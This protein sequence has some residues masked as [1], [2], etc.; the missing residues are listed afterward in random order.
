MGVRGNAQMMRASTGEE[1]STGAAATPGP[2]ETFDETAQRLFSAFMQ[3]P[4]D[5]RAMNEIMYYMM[6]N[7]PNR[8]GP[9]PAAKRVVESLE[10]ETIDEE[11]AKRLETCAICTEDFAAGDRI[12][13]LSNDR[14]LCG[15]GFHVDCILPWLRQ[16]N[17]C[18]VCRYE[19]PTDDEQYN[20]QRAQLRSRLVE[21]VQRHVDP[22]SQPNSGRQSFSESG[23][24]GSPAPVETVADND[25]TASPADAASTANPGPS[26][27]AE[28]AT[29]G[30]SNN[31]RTS[32][33]RRQ[34]SGG[35]LIIETNN[36]RVQ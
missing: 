5:P 15:H 27:P 24:T 17:S 22:N 9:P 16:H 2:T 10:V 19:L 4:F 34:A 30:T 8:Q 35:R 13:W 20:L 29:T 28:A 7:D 12:H 18:P 32:S 3:N 1:P 26:A 11:T 36:C 21:E 31:P 14:S 33:Q 25:S 6:E 23:Q